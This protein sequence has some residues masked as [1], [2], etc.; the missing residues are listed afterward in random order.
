[1]FILFYFLYFL[2]VLFSEAGSLNTKLILLSITFSDL[3]LTVLSTNSVLLPMFISQK[4]CIVGRLLKMC[5]D[6]CFVS[7]SCNAFCSTDSVSAPFKAKI[8]ASVQKE[9]KDAYIVLTWFANTESF[10]HLLYAYISKILL[11]FTIFFF[12]KGVYVQEN[13]I[14]DKLR[15]TD[16]VLL[17]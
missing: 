5:N 3:F 7:K 15:K 1:M 11:A 2:A 17:W 8:L 10:T 13:G 6:R 12:F 14:P 4:V 9:S 16:I